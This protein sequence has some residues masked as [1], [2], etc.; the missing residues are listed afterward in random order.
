MKSNS[1]E[2]PAH[3][4]VLIG[5][6]LQL[7]VSSLFDYQLSNDVTAVTKTR[8]S[9]QEFVDFVAK[10]HYYMPVKFPAICHAEFKYFLL[11]VTLYMTVLIWEEL[12]LRGF[13]SS[14]SQPSCKI[15][16]YIQMRPPFITKIMCCLSVVPKYF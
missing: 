2:L 8:F 16:I 10:M 9:L 6:T 13:L 15:C 12:Y 11:N 14:Q 3:S 7:V 5:Y 4:A 1:N